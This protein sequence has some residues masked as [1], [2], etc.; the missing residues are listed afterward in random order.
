[1]KLADSVYDVFNIPIHEIWVDPEFNCRDAFT[2]DDV[3][4]LA[5]TIESETLLFPVVVQPREDSYEMPLGFR[6]RLICGFRRTE[7]CKSLGW[8]TIPANVRPGLNERQAQLMNLTENLERKNLNILEEAKA[9]DRIFPP[10][11]TDQSIATELKKNRKWV[12][13]R[14]KLMTLSETIQQAVA[15]GRLSARDLQAIIAH[16]SPDKL[17]EDLLRAGAKRRKYEIIQRGKQ[18]RNKSEVQALIA[19]M[20]AE[21]FHPNLLRLMGWAIGEVDD[22]GLAESRRWLKDRKGWLK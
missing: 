20:L 17:A 19:E 12:S 8:E 14:R 22:E 21:G 6:F 3:L 7:A 9:L 2:R 1:M 16:P 18:K 11:R 15:S 5:G 4:D 10:Y 13:V